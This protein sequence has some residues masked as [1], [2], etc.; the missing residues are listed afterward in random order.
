MR[1]ARA[2]QSSTGIQPE[3]TAELTCPELTPEGPK[4]ATVLYRICRGRHER[5]I[6][7]FR[8]L[9]DDAYGMASQLTRFRWASED[10][11]TVGSA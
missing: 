5:P 6:S 9:V 8:A 2:P 10:P 3:P 1:A 11:R 4:R 7:T